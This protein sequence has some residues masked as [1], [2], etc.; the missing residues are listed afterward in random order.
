[1]CELGFADEMNCIIWEF[2][3]FILQNQ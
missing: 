2:E 1:L 3:N